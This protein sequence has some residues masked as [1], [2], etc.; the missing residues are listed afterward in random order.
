MSHHC[1][2]VF[3]GFITCGTGHAHGS[4]SILRIVRAADGQ[5]AGYDRVFYSLWVNIRVG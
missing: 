4:V 3:R 5:S 2:R 1:D